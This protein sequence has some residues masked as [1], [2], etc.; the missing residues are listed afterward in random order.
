L[1]SKRSSS[2]PTP[3]SWNAGGGHGADGPLFPV[4]YPF[5]VAA[6]HDVSLLETQVCVEQLLPSTSQYF[7]ADQSSL[8]ARLKGVWT[9]SETLPLRP[10][11][12]SPSPC[13]VWLIL[14]SKYILLLFL[15]PLRC[16]LITR[17][18]RVYRA[19]LRQCLFCLGFVLPLVESLIWS[20]YR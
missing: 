1:S 8:A 12:P 2:R 6:Y 10:G 7:C 4:Q 3:T 20:S 17:P 11:P 16:W 19:G 13:M 9:Q 18:G 15:F 14:G 5:I